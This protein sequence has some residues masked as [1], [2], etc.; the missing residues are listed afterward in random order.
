[1]RPTGLFT[2]DSTTMQ[3]GFESHSP[4]STLV[5]IQENVMKAI[6]NLVATLL[7]DSF[8]LVLVELAAKKLSRAFITKSGRSS[9][10]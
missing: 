5:V 3:E 4:R 9:G 10:I 7:W 2:H 1:M 8:H 6:C